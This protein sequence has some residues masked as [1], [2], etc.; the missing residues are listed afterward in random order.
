MRHSISILPRLMAGPTLC[1]WGCGAGNTGLSQCNCC[2]GLFHHQCAGK[3]G[4]D[5]DR[6]TLCGRWVSMPGCREGATAVEPPAP[7]LPQFPPVQ[8][9]PAQ[10]HQHVEEDVIDLTKSTP[11]PSR[12]DNP[13]AAAWAAAN[14]PS[15]T[16]TAVLSKL[17]SAKEPHAA[18]QLPGRRAQEG[19][20]RRADV[21]IEETVVR[22]S[23][24]TFR[25]AQRF[26]FWVEHFRAFCRGG[27]RAWGI[28]FCRG[29][30]EHSSQ[31]PTRTTG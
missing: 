12:M 29:G 20:P 31:K 7:V 25:S 14:P 30:P 9:P 21:L 1:V 28:E 19:A 26:F 13:L 24:S 17:P 22:P 10:Q 8:Q 16:V 18:V 23:T 6:G 11:K 27:E 4:Q 3:A 5:G 2:G 15:A